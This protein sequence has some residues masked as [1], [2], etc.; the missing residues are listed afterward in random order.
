M[1]RS[2]RAPAFVLL[3]AALCAAVAAPAASA[4]EGADLSHFFCYEARTAEPRAHGLDV[5][6]QLDQQV[7]RPIRA[8]Q[9]V[10]YCNPASLTEGGRRFPVVEEADHLT[11]YAVDPV[12]PPR[13]R[14]TVENHLTAGAEI[15]Q[16][17]EA[18]WLMVPTRQLSPL[19]HR[20]P[21]RLDHYLC[22]GV[23]GGTAGRGEVELEDQ[24]GRWPST[25]VGRPLA[26]CNPA[27]V[28]LGRRTT[29]VENPGT[30]L[31]C[32]E[33]D[34]PFAASV[35]GESSFG[36]EDLNLTRAFTLCVPSAQR[37]R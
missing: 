16:L 32:Y 26:V 27:E 31:V 5:R 13:E 11:V 34:R 19:K 28:R 15:L 8:V 30:P 6:D 12:E 20:A 2:Y 14:I 36:D 10:S 4:Q 29:A 22:Y 3:A 35:G 7:R 24:F 17:E 23:V 18:R 25:P 9:P 37:E 33:V 1:R 21:R